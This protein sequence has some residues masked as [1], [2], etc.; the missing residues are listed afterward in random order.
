MIFGY[1]PLEG[2]ECARFSLHGQILQAEYAGCNMLP[3]HNSADLMP[4]GL[5]QGFC[6]FSADVIG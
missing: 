4:A 1:Y 5:R 3:H 2:R 6:Q